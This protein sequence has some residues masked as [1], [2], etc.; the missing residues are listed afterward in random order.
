MIKKKKKQEKLLEDK[1]V[2]DI[3]ILGKEDNTY[4]DALERKQ[5]E[6]ENLR[7]KNMEGVKVRSRACW[8]CDGKKVTKYFC[9]LETRHYVGKCMI[10]LTS[11]SQGIN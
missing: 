7:K 9:N 8:I 3:E 10:S 6:L 5:N 2:E 1:L 11:Y 4:Y